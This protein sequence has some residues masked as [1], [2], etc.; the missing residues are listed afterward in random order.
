MFRAI[1]VNIPRKAAAKPTFE[2]RR[3]TSSNS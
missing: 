3:V 1:L 2:N